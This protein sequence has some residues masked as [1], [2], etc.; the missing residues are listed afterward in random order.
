MDYVYS[1]SPWLVP[2]A[3]EGVGEL[4]RK[5]GK[6]VFFADH[7]EIYLGE[8][9][10]V[11]YITSG[12]FA[13]AAGGVGDFCKAVGLFPAGSVLGA[14]RTFTHGSGMPLVARALFPLEA[15]SIPAQR[16]V[17][18]VENDPGL[19][20]DLLLNFVRISESELEGLL[21][22]SLLSVPER[23]AM[24]IATLF[25]AS[26]EGELGDT[27]RPLPGTIS[28]TNLAGLVHTSRVVVS[29]T[30]SKWAA[31]GL[32]ERSGNDYLFT[33]RMFSVLGKKNGAKAAGA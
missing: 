25:R 29:R 12:L 20:S 1:Q 23:L 31:A 27:P 22:N 8:D 11:Y 24:M 16:F 9:E 7:E 3:P 21:I 19:R 14:V 30:L 17:S 15:L 13:T 5:H 26:G 4:F 18:L 32:I 33:K 28:V 6:A 10:T 2:K